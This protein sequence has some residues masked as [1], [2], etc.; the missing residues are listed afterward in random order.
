MGGAL[1]EGRSPL[2]RHAIESYNSHTESIVESSPDELERRRE[3]GRQRLAWF[4]AEI[5]EQR[6]IK[7]EAGLIA[8]END[9]DAIWER[10]DSIL[11]EMVRTPATSLQGVIVKLGWAME[12]AAAPTT[13]EDF[14]YHNA[15]AD[16]ERLA[17]GA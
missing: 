10:Q 16:L 8:A 2:L 11:E 13:T 4:D 3:Q 7:S 6:R 15:L 17:G 1:T 9:A 12:D 14:A 5:A